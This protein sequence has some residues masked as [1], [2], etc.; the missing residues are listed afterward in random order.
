MLSYHDL[1]SRAIGVVTMKHCRHAPRALGLFLACLFFLHWSHGAELPKGRGAYV[2]SG[3]LASPHATQAAAADEQFV[4]AV[5]NTHV[6]QY[7]RASQKELAK[8]TGPAEHLNSA[9]L[10]KG[11]VLC[12]HSNYPKKPHQSDIRALDPRTMDLKVFHVFTDPPGSLTWAV[13]R[14]PHWWCHFA[15]YGKDHA[16][17]VLVQYDEQWKE[18]GRWTYPKNLVADWGNYSLSGGI[19]HEGDLLATGHDKQ[20]IYRLKVPERGKEVIVLEVLSS[21][22]P[23]QGI[24]SD[25]KTGGL[26]G[27]DRAKRQILFASFRLETK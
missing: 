25:P 2:V 18:L 15:H 8:S 6:V 16:K 3:S 9:F 21:P 24:A 1:L 10:W 26:V 14:G 23:G 13:R 7:D 4:Y 22:F 19:W 5:S 11:K 12:A 17:S 20:M 27:I